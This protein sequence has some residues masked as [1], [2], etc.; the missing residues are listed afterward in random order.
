MKHYINQ[1]VTI[2]GTPFKIVGVVDAFTLEVVSTDPAPEGSKP[3]IQVI[4]VSQI[5][6]VKS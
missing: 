2:C 4:D 3:A 1:V 5:D 6:E